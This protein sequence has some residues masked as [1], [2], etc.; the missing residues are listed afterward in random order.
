MAEVIVL[1]E[2]GRYYGTG[3]KWQILRYWQK[4]A[5]VTMLAENGRSFIV[6]AENG[7]SFTML[8]ENGRSYS[9]VRK[10]QIAVENMG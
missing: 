2:N 6:L 8:A 3:R 4:M 1:A 7:R 9:T 5:E 10:W